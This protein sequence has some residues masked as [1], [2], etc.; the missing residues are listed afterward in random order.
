M[1][2]YTGAIFI[3]AIPRSGLQEVVGLLTRPGSFW[4]LFQFKAYGNGAFDATPVGFNAFP[5][6]AG[7]L[8]HAEYGTSFGYQRTPDEI[9]PGR[10]AAIKAWFDAARKVV[11]KYES[12]GRY[13]GYVCDGD[14]VAA[15][16]GPNYSRL[17]AAKQRYDPGNVF[18]NALSVP[19]PGGSTTYE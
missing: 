7:T 2:R 6:R 18:R 13:N 5:Y 16:F 4:R 10:A 15:Y 12:G 14:A 11:A 9:E 3:A 19:P 8:M 1:P 17:R